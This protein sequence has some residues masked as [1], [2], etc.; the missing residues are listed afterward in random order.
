MPRSVGKLVA[1]SLLAHGADLI[2]CVPGESFLGLT[3]AMT[4][5]PELRLIVCRHEGGA[6]YMAVADGRMRGGR[7]GLCLVS[8]GPGVANAMIGLHTAFHDCVP[9]LLLVG[10]IERRDMGRGALQEQNYGKLLSDVTK[11]VIEVAQ[12]SQV[13]EAIARAYHLA[14][15]GTPG[16]VALIL[17]EDLLDDP[18]DDLPPAAPRPRTAPQPSAA[19]LDELAAR[20]AAAERPL[21]HLGS[22]AD[23]T[24][25]QLAAI[26][27]LA[28]RWMLPVA[29][30]HRWPHLFDSAHPHY[31]GYVGNRVQAKLMAAMKRADL[32][33][34]LGE[35]M[36]DVVSQSYTWPAAPDPQLPFVHVWPDPVEINRVFR[37]ELPIVADP[38][39]VVAGLLARKPAFPLR[40]AAWIATLNGI[41]RELTAPRHEPAPD[42][43]NFAA[44][45][46]ALAERMASDAMLSTDAGNFTSFVHR[47]VPFGPRRI[48]LGS[49][50]GGMGAAVPMTVAAALRHPG[51]QAIAVVGDGGALMTGNEIA[52]AMRHGAAPLILIADN[53]TYGSIGMHHGNRYPGRPVAAAADLVNPDFAAWARAFGAEGYTIRTEEEIAPALDAALAPRRVPAVVHVHASALQVTAWRR[54]E[55]TTPR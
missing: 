39:A 46:I 26:A 29:P 10:Q 53:R 15:S 22:L 17:P 54:A 30:T 36:T 1:E 14:E 32:L 44:V 16:P 20:L 40:R 47:H 33:V 6:S 50:V 21:V 27:D 18:A 42:G 51:R 49:A 28:E 25:E 4:D 37:A 48:F 24:P 7:A 31:A 19:Q 45:C 52:T 34:A 2:F 38:H 43:V 23:G 3:D 5:L 9:M 11:A 13:S 12:P 35:R 55:A 8:R 41:H